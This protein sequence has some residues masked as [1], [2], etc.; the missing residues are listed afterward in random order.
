MRTSA[1]F[2]MT[3]AL[4]A[5]FS[6][7]QEPPAAARPSDGY[8]VHVSAP[9]M[10]DGKVMGPYEHYC[11]VLTQDPIIVCQIYESTDANAPM[12]QVEDIIGKKLTRNGKV[13][14]K[15]WNKLWHD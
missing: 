11:K 9:H 5:S 14:L 6:L 15:D 10:V 8:T 2:F 13:T 4:I 3:L 1:L 7:A 12:V